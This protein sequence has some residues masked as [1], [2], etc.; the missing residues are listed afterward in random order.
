MMSGCAATSL[1]PIAPITA[2]Q[3]SMIGPNSTPIAPVPK[4]CSANSAIRIAT[5]NGTTC[6]ASPG[7]ATCEA[8]RPPTR[9]EM[10]GVSMPSP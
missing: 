2:N 6:A 7:E 5:E 10:A 1:A 4:R 8:R 9:T 3:I